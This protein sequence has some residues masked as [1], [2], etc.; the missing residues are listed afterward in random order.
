VEIGNRKHGIQLKA[1]D[2][3]NEK[4]DDFVYSSSV[5]RVRGSK[6]KRLDTTKID[7]CEVPALVKRPV[8]MTGK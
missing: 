1:V 2:S 3:P 6:V 4:L 8:S 5:V 7:T